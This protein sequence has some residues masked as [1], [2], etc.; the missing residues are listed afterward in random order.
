MNINTHEQ[1]LSQQG[2]VW[3]AIDD[4]MQRTGNLI[5]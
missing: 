4:N 2:K 3:R 5:H 1:L